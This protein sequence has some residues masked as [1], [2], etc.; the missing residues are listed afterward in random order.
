MVK[1]RFINIIYRALKSY[2]TLRYYYKTSKVISVFLT[3]NNIVNTIIYRLIGGKTGQ[4]I[5]N[6]RNDVP[7]QTNFLIRILYRMILSEEIVIITNF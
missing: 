6:E 2:N 4:L 5:L 1:I 7:K 3:E